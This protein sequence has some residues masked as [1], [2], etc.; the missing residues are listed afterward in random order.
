MFPLH[1]DTILM[2]ALLAAGGAMAARRLTAGALSLVQFYARP[3]GMPIPTRSHFNY[4]QVVSRLSAGEKAGYHRCTD[5]IPGPQTRCC[6][7]WQPLTPEVLAV[8]TAKLGPVSDRETPVADA[9]VA[10]RTLLSH[11]SPHE[12]Q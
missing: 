10:L 7:I 11:L 1:E 5:S 6:T 9:Q 2:L 12:G 8:S 4:D 3:D